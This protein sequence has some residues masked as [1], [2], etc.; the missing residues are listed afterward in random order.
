MFYCHA[1]RH[2]TVG[3]SSVRTTDIA[4]RTTAELSPDA[5][6]GDLLKNITAAAERAERA[7]D[8]MFRT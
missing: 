7:P 8:R 2:A 6:Q 4:C 3:R 5:E 1:G